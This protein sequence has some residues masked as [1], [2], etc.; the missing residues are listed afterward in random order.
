M[1]IPKPIHFVDKESQ[2][3]SH[4]L[5]NS[6]SETKAN[7]GL[8][9]NEVS[10]EPFWKAQGYKCRPNKSK[11]DETD[12]DY[13]IWSSENS[14]FNIFFSQI[15]SVAAVDLSYQNQLLFKLKNDFISGSN[16][17]TP[18]IR[19]S[20]PISNE[21]SLNLEYRTFDENGKSIFNEDGEFRENTESEDLV[22][23][24]INFLCCYGDSIF[25]KNFYSDELKESLIQFSNRVSASYGMFKSNPEISSVYVGRD[26]D[27]ISK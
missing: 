26:I 10:R 3:L 7:G 9:W 24:L 2:R 13:V 14:Y 20:S 6:L 4:I 12:L 11:Q 22:K 27:Y 15:P 16:L 25:W 17:D 19:F 5:F 1:I 21:P 23:Y 8:N 18:E